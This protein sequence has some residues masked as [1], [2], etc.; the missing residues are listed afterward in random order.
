MSE[1]SFIKKVNKKDKNPVLI[2]NKV[3]TT[4]PAEPK[5]EEDRETV[6]DKMVRN[7]S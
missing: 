1:K 5:K 4:T 2:L 6:K 3:A 7:A